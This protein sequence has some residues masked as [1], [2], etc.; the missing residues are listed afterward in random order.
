MAAQCRNKRPAEER[1][2]TTAADAAGL[3]RQDAAVRHF[4]ATACRR[5]QLAAH[6]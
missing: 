5:L 1:I 2:A 6:A 4:R 3:A